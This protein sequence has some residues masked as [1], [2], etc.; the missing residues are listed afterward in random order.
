MSIWSWAPSFRCPKPFVLAD[1]S[2]FLSDL[3][4]SLRSGH[5]RYSRNNPFSEWFRVEVGPEVLTYP[6]HRVSQV[7]VSLNFVKRKLLLASSC[8]LVFFDAL[9]ALPPHF[10]SP[11]AT[12]LEQERATTWVTVSIA[13]VRFAAI[14]F[15]KLSML[16][17]IRRDGWQKDRDDYQESR[18]T[19]F[20]ATLPI[21][22]APKRTSPRHI[23]IR[24]RRPRQLHYCL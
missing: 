22:E 11:F 13:L 21:H 5:K 16:T 2:Q 10:L 12:P 20:A 7:K 17:F 6:R 1:L 8:S 3:I 19:T 15:A 23:R 24:Y 9:Q 14:R 18:C 4:Y